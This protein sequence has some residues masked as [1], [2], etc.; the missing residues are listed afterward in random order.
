MSVQV[1]EKDGKPEW[2]VIPY[3]E[4]ERL[5]EEAEALKDIRAYDQAKKAV[6]EGEE[7]IP[8]E[9][10]YAILDGANPIRAWREYRGLSRKK[11]AE[12]SGVSAEYLARVEAGR[13]EASLDILATIADELGLSVDDI[14]DSST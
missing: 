4:Y 6:A 11:L 7:V 14:I 13:T 9:V 3:N 1:I 5:L 12:A 8:G 2:A 10:V